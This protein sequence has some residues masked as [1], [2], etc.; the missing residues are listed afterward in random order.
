MPE[1]DTIHRTAQTL[2]RALAGQRVMRF[3]T[4]YAHL[5]RV[6]DESAITGRIIERVEAAGKHLLI[7]FSGDLALR[8]HMRMHGAWHLYRPGERWRAPAHAV[9]IRL[10][11]VDWVA[12]AVDVPVANFVATS[13]L[14]RHAP[15]AQLGPDLLAAGFDQ[16]AAGARWRA[17]GTRAIGDVLLDQRIVAGLGNVLRCEVLFM[18]GVHPVR[19]ASALSDEELATLAAVSRRAMRFE[20]RQWGTPD[21]GAAQPGGATLGLRAGWAPLPEV[22]HL[23]RVT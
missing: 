21:D 8:T 1:G 23:H 10:D 11:T 14:P 13:R 19:A 2:Q 3:D 5:A 17:A 16:D 15:V 20:P 6:H 22:R 7:I 12:L 18:S 4:G 9:R